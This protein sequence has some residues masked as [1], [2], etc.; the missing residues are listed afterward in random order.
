MPNSAVGSPSRMGR[1][2]GLVPGVVVADRVNSG[3]TD[4]SRN[5]EGSPFG[6]IGEDSMLGSRTRSDEHHDFRRARGGGG[7]EDVALP[8]G[9]SSSSNGDSSSEDKVGELLRPSPTRR[10]G[11]D[12]DRI[13]PPGGVGS[14]GVSSPSKADQD[15][16]ADPFRNFTFIDYSAL[17]MANLERINKMREESSLASTL[18]P[19]GSSSSGHRGMRRASN[20]TP[21]TF[22]H[23]APP[24]AAAMGVASLGRASQN[25]VRGAA[26]L[27]DGTAAGSPPPHPQAFLSRPPSASLLRCTTVDRSSASALS[28]G[29]G[30]AM[31][32]MSL[33]SAASIAAPGLPAAATLLA[34]QPSGSS[35][36]SSRATSMSGSL[37]AAGMRLQH[38]S[39]RER[40]SP[41]HLPRTLLEAAA[42]ASADLQPGAAAGT[43]RVLPRCEPCYQG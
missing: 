9:L 6:G 13:S 25:V 15:A 24:S 17:S 26:P 41:H 39:S 38:Q 42:A 14:G 4:S 22:S 7:E 29:G 11:G 21:P 28:P 2:S 30:G 10:T 36:G 34:S 18:S 33:A 1:V 43:G 12:A 3:G 20:L 8:P 19:A 23:L 32:R 5:D 35:S 31:S 16:A 37:G 40:Q 27:W